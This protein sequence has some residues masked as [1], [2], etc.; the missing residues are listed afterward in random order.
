MTGFCSRSAFFAALQRI[1]SA[2]IDLLYLS[3]TERTSYLHLVMAVYQLREFGIT[4][5]A[6]KIDHGHNPQASLKIFINISFLLTQGMEQ[7]QAV[8]SGSKIS[9]AFNYRYL[10]T[11]SN[12]SL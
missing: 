6:L 11:R 4:I 2:L 9:A 3:V 5:P 10:R 1:T 8:N 7:L 12:T